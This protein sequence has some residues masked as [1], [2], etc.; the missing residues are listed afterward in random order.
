MENVVY[1]VIV[2]NKS[3]WREYDTASLQVSVGYEK[4]TG[5]KCQAILGWAKANFDKVIICVN[6]TLQCYNRAYTS[7]LHHD[8][9]S[10]WDL[11]AQEGKDWLDSNITSTEKLEIY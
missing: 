9:L 3:N 4:H 11:T 1:K 6:D 5:D 2:K 7:E 8:D 10:L